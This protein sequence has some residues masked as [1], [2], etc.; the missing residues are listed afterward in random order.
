MRSRCCLF[1]FVGY[2]TAG[3]VTTFQVCVMLS[4]WFC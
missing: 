1:C 2:N 4:E 3:G